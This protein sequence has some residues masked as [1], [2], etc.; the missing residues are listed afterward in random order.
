MVKVG[1]QDNVI[2]RLSHTSKGPTPPLTRRG[3]LRPAQPHAAADDARGGIDAAKDHVHQAIVIQITPHV[4]TAPKSISGARV[5]CPAAVGT[6]TNDAAFNTGL[7]DVINLRHEIQGPV[8]V[9]IRGGHQGHHY[10]RRRWQ[11][12]N[13]HGI[14]SSHDGTRLAQHC[15]RRRFRK[16]RFTDGTH[17]RVLELRK[18]TAWVVSEALKLV[19][20]GG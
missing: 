11:S 8:T 4:P 14:Q 17:A 6:A 15:A 7:F 3:L 2:A 18:V 13:G 20:R 9:D 1:A 5:H 10:S 12:I 16:D 19:K